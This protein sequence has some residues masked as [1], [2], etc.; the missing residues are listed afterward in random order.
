VR[1][2]DKQVAVLEKGEQISIANNNIE[3]INRKI[4]KD[5]ET[6]AWQHGQMI[7]DDEAISDI[8]L[9][10]EKT[11]DVQISIENA[12]LKN[13]HIST[14]FNKAAGIEKALEILSRLTDCKIISE[15]QTYI[16]K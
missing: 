15:R 1:Y 13:L 16:L 11:F 6:A 12:E 9:Y 4:L 10:L 8:V 7:F 2:S 5:E 3:Q 14:G